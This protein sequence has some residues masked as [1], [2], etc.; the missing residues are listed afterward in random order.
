MYQ[1]TLQCD[2]ASEELRPKFNDLLS[3]HTT[4][5]CDLFSPSKTCTD[6]KTCTEK[7]T[8]WWVNL[9]HST[10]TPLVRSFD[11]FWTA[12]LHFANTGWM[13][14]TKS[15][16]I[17]H[18]MLNPTTS[19]RN[20]WENYVNAIFTPEYRNILYKKNNKVKI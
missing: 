2:N 1:R 14:E 11:Y 4:F 13:N 7:Q 17:S 15:H 5:C 10:I 18:A 20:L 6:C 8:R 12:P 9:T 16:K 19:C 3:T